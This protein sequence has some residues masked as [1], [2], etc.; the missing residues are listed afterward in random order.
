MSEQGTLLYGDE[1]VRFIERIED[2]VTKSL[3]NMAFVRLVRRASLE[4]TAAPRGDFEG[5][6]FQLLTRAQGHSRDCDVVIGMQMDRGVFG[7]R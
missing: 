5:S 1:A 6:H 3:V 7:G 2:P 4:K